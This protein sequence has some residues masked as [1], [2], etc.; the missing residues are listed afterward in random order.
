MIVK[1]KISEGRTGEITRIDPTTGDEK[2]L[3]NSMWVTRVEAM[4]IE[5]DNHLNPHAARST[6]E[7]RVRAKHYGLNIDW[8]Q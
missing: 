1:P 5:E 2:V 8:K 4:A 6:A 7:F 3:V